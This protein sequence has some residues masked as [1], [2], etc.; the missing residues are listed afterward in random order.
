MRKLLLTF[1]TLWLFATSF[2]QVGQLDSSFGTNGFK[3]LGDPVDLDGY[4]LIKSFPDDNG[5]RFDVMGI[6]YF[7]NGPLFV[8]K[9]LKDGSLD[10]TYGTNGIS[11]GVT[12]NPR[13]VVRQADGRITAAG[14]IEN[15]HSSPHHDL[16]MYRF[17]TNGTVDYSY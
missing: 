13:S 12:M 5:G 10:A 14:V 16:V 4:E 17:A 3:T 1:L 6:T 2:A 11:D 7:T 8:V 15:E 9:Y